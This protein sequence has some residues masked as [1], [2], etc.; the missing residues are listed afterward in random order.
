RDLAKSLS[1]VTLERDGLVAAV[2]ELADTSSV[3]LGIDC[4]SDIDVLQLDLDRT[5][6][7]HLYRIIQEAVNNS[8]RHGKAKNVRIEVRLQANEV[9]VKVID[10]GS[11]LSQKTMSKPG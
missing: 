7:L 6:A 10:D 2:E 5:R 9:V 8:V 11:G 3:L 4:R 1:P